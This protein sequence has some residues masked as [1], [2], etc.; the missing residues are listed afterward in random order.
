MIRNKSEYKYKTPFKGPYEN[1]QT[2]KNITVTLQ[3]VA[4]TNRI[5]ICRINTYT[6]T[7]I[8]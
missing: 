1:F 5:N 7:N 4:V 8:Q 3:M 2:W 6:N